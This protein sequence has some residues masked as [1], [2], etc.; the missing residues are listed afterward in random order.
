MPDQPL[1]DYENRSTPRTEYEVNEAANFMHLM[2]DYYLADGRKKHAEAKPT[3]QEMGFLYFYLNRVAEA[4]RAMVR[5]DWLRG[6]QFIHP[7]PPEDGSWPPEG[8]KAPEPVK[9]PKKVADDP[10]PPR[11]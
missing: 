1:A 6:G 7:W 5:N 8:W 9:R 2:R 10:P 3:N 4:I 11:D